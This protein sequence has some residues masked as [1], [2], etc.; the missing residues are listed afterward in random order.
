MAKRSAR[1][2]E[3]MIRGDQPLAQY[4]FKDG[5]KRRLIK[6]L[7]EEGWPIYDVAGKRCGL[8][9]E[10]DAMMAKTF[11]KIR[12]TRPRRRH[13]QRETEATFYAKRR[14]GGRR[15]HFIGAKRSLLAKPSLW[16]PPRP[17]E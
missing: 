3:G 2:L 6:Q 7:Q 4:I 17:Q 11:E 12:P 5:R 8:P 10:L 1:T 9:D 13:R 16:A 15:S 14:P